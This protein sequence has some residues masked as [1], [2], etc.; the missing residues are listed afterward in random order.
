MIA[1]CAFFAFPP[2]RN[3][4][5]SCLFPPVTFS[6]SS[7]IEYQSLRTFFENTDPEL[8]FYV[9][10]FILFLLHIFPPRWQTSPFIKP[11]NVS[12]GISQQTT[13][14][15]FSTPQYSLT[16]PFDRIFEFLV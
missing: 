3:T 14:S 5:W 4:Q 9:A 11:I 7:C 16:P 8:R 10:I 12:S 13:Y 6:H 1:D 2:K 15:F